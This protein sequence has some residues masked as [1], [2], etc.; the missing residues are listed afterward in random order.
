MTNKEVLAELKICYELLQDIRENNESRFNKEEETLMWKMGEQINDLYC[1]VYKQ[2]LESEYKDDDL[3]IKTKQDF[4]DEEIVIGNDVYTD[5]NFVK[6]G[7]YDLI[8]DKYNDFDYLTCE[9]LGYNWYFDEIGYKHT[10]W[11][12]DKLASGFMKA[13][14]E[15]CELS[16]QVG[17]EFDYYDKTCELTELRNFESLDLLDR[18][19]SDNDE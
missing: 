9:D 5:Y 12:Y 2:T 6:K 16:K 18:Y 19:G 17:K 3:K 4:G 7:T 14:D 1:K 13:L 10:N 8:K 11:E 15:I